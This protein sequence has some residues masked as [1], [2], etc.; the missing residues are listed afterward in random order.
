MLHTCHL[1]TGCKMRSSI[2]QPP[3][4]F[5]EYPSASHWWD[6]WP[7]L[8]HASPSSPPP[9][10]PY[11]PFPS[12]EFDPHLIIPLSCLTY[13]G[14]WIWTWHK[15]P[16]TLALYPISLSLNLYPFND[17]AAFSVSNTPQSLPPRL[18]RHQCPW[19]RTSVPLS[20]FL[21][22]LCQYDLFCYYYP[23]SPCFHVS[24]L[25]LSVCAFCYR[26]ML[27]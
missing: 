27:F 19:P 10:S 23:V 26:L 1:Q 15:R 14:T 17:E 12:Q 3:Q 8:F 6:S 2:S 24:L 16:F 11:F 25:F 7:P 22:T 5:Q 13:S 4:L 18:L 20:S 21:L 9:P